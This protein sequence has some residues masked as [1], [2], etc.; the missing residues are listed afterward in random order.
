MSRHYW[1]EYPVDDPDEEDDDDTDEDDE[2][3]DDEE[4]DEEEPET[5]QVSDLT[6]LL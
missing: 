6:R 4:T 2:D 3:G 1:L 5:W